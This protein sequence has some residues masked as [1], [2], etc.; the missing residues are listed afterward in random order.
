MSEA[1]GDHALQPGGLKGWEPEAT[2]AGALSFLRCRYRSDPTGVEVAVTGVPLDTATTNR[3][4]TRFGPRGI[5]AA[6]SIMAWERPYGWDFDPREVLAIA[7][8]GD[9]VFDPFHPAGVPAE[10]EAHAD[11]LIGAGCT[12]LTLGGDHFVTWPLLKAHA[13]RHGPLS[14]LHFDA[15]SDTWAGSPD[16]SDINHGTMFWHAAREGLIDVE[17]SLQVGLRTHNPDTLGIPIL[18]APWVHANGPAAVVARAR[19][20]LAGRKVYLTFDID[21]L[22]PAFA[23]GTGTPVVGGL[24]TAQALAILKGLRGLDL[25]GADIVEV[26][27]AYDSGEITALAAAQIGFEILALFACRPGG[28]M[29]A[30]WP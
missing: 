13:R 2:Y 25:A 12:L 3:P 16:G 18:D 20:L 23:P 8:L 27:P 28:P 26:A 9:C 17:H 11:R 22:D 30:G 1:K 24:A 4:G 14:L 5:R 29:P 7:D 10:I 6:S 19:E 15:H 21:G